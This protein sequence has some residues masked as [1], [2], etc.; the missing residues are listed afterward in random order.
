MKQRLKTREEKT[1]T[2]MDWKKIAV[3]GGGIS[4]LAT[5]W[6]LREEAL[7]QGRRIQVDLFEKE[8]RPGGKFE[9]VEQEGYII[10]GGPNGFL[11]NKPWTLDLVRFLGMEDRL[12]T[13]DQ[14]AARRFIYSRGRLHEL[15]PSILSFFLNGPLSV[16]GRIRIAGEF[17]ATPTPKGEDTSL[18][19]FARRRLGSEALERLI[20]P[21]V[22][23]IFA[24]DP[25][26]MSLRASFPRIAELEENF[27]GLTKALLKLRRDR[28][29]AKRRGEE[30]TVSSG[31]SGPG[32]VLT[33]FKSGVRELTD[34]LAGELD[35]RFHGKE[36]V[37]TLEGKDGRWRVVSSGGDYTA[38][39]VILAMPSDAAAGL[40]AP[41]AP[42]AAQLLFQIPYSPMAVVGLGYRLADLAPPPHGFGYLIPSV[43]GINLLG[44]LWDSAIFPGF[45][46]DPDHFLIRA[47]V[48]GAQDPETPTLPEDVLLD[49]TLKNLARTMGLSAK[50]VFHALFRWEKAIPL[51]TV[52]HLERL[53]RTES[54]LP[55]GIFLTG[56]AYRGVGI[57]DCV[58]DARTTAI[59]TLDLL[60]GQRL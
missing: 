38:D 41:I 3:I 26:R 43:E 53:E 31:P 14:A 34:R 55:P 25:S 5:A 7:K 48:G 39:S 54:H 37:F 24:G 10:E 13:S 49:F 21:M 59:K 52:G 16:A 33:S 20:D 4:G 44:A 42:E 11:D 29:R 15:K 30:V 57:N 2:P 12:L 9:T 22:S 46:S 45:R 56:N 60:D 23:G 27:G 8:A 18:A 35:D 40:L 51:Y 58:R 32:G 19:E 28:I 50:P 6:F 36:Q 47:M 17:L 1:I